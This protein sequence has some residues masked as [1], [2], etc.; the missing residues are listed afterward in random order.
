MII[1]AGIVLGCVPGKKINDKHTAE[2][3]IGGVNGSPF[4]FKP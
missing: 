3:L 2:D 1:F 4:S